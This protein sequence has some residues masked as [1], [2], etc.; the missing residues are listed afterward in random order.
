MERF[1]NLRYTHLSRAHNQF[2]EALATLA[3]MIDIPEGVV[4][5]P[6]LVETRVVLAYYCLIDDLGFDDGMP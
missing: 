3:S 5:L 2:V 4:S 1:D 6:L